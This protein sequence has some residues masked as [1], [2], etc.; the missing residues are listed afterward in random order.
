MNPTVSLVMLTYKQS[1][2]IEVA[3]RSALEQNY[4][5]L[6][7]IVSDD[8]SPD[9]TFDR[10]QA[11][12]SNYAGPHR[13]HV[14]RNHRNLGTGSNLSQAVQQSTGELIV[15]AAGDDISLPDR[16]SQL[17]QAW[18]NTGRTV[19]LLAS[20]VTDMDE[21]GWLHDVI[22]SS[23]LQT[24]KTL[25]DW[26]NQR[27]HIVGASQAWTRRLFDRFGP[28]PEG[29]VSEDLIMVFR[30]IASGG[31]LTL[32]TPLVH[33][34]RGGVSGKKRHLT[35]K[36]M[37]DAWLKSSRS[38]S[39]EAQVMLK[40]CAAVNAPKSV[41]NYLHNEFLKNQYILALFSP[42]SRLSRFYQGLIC[43]G[44]PWNK[45]LRFITYA[46]L[47]E[48]LLPFYWLKSKIR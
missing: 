17:A 40:D 18:E 42:K 7:I 15:L 35:P 39:I 9:D 47:P 6:E 26:V 24:L 30:A 46:V 34:R 20:Y 19:D 5:N 13:L 23:Q 37:I 1:D 48:L 29:V 8:A 32:T 12:A 45:R 27:P 21:S 25:D 36:S 41:T 16:C 28:L 33:Y 4:P 2:T 31:A 43:R 38:G 11:I 22:E 44:M 3:L 10:I 14:H